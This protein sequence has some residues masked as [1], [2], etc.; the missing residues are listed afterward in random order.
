VYLNGKLISSKNYYN[1]VAYLLAQLSYPTDY[2]TDLLQSSLYYPDV[3]AGTLNNT[4]S[5]YQKRAAFIKESKSVELCGYLFDDIFLQDK[6][7]LSGIDIRLKLKRSSP[8]FALLSP[9]VSSEYNIIF[10]ECVLYVKRNL[11]SPKIV[12]LHERTLE[13]TKALYPY[14][15]SNV[16][17]LSLPVGTTNFVA[18][19]IYPSR[20]LPQTLLI[21]LVETAGFQG[22]YDKNPY[23]FNHFNLSNINVSVDNLNLEYR[24]LN[25]AFD[26]NYLLAYQTLVTGLNLEHSSVGINRSNYLDGNILFCYQLCNFNGNTSF[27]DKTGNLKIE[28]NFKIALDKQVTVIILSQ[29]S[30]VLMVDKHRSIEL[31]NQGV[32]T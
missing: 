30:A 1:Y 27:A 8:K 12:D 20:K 11:I 23:Q 2:K 6:W 29:E 18:E 7:L 25:L 15:L 21:G 26:T 19:N 4:N 9:V 22:S 3:G 32:L 14:I 5:G 31:E 17:T 10:D 28:L 24:N 13:R 16:K